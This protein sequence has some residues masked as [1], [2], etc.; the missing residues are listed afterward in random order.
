MDFAK[1]V[2]ANKNSKKTYKKPYITLKNIKNIKFVVFFLCLISLLKKNCSDILNLI[3]GGGMDLKIEENVHLE[4]LH[5]IFENNSPLNAYDSS[6]IDDPTFQKYVSI[7]ADMPIGYLAL[8]PHNDFMQKE[9]LHSKFVPEENSVYIWHLVVRKAFE[10]KGVASS[11]MKHVVGEYGNVP[12]YAVIEDLNAA[13]IKIY[14]RF[15]FK[16]FA[17][18][19]RSF[20]TYKSSFLL[21]KRK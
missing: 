17:K 13:A 5:Q 12:I 18:F 15:G 14:E 7:F 9:G 16:I 6:C 19:N 3:K 21:M 8:Y 10:G 1:N 2:Q 20:G 4:R 11:L